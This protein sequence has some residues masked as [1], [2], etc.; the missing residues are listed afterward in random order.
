MYPKKLT[1][2]SC[3]SGT[4][5]F[6]EPPDPEDEETWVALERKAQAGK[7]AQASQD[8]AKEDRTRQRKQLQAI[9]LATD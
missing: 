8:K 1:W 7:A 5:G 4:Q 9:E 3:H 6:C 2:W